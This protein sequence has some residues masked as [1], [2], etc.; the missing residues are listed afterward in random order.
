MAELDQKMLQQALQEFETEQSGGV[1][2][3]FLC[4]AEV[5]SMDLGKRTAY[6][7]ISS[8][9]PAMVVGLAGYLDERTRAWLDDRDE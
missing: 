4:V 3:A 5:S 8:G 2:T 1:V 7:I 6:R 9:S